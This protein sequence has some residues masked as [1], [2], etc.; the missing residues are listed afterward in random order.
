[1]VYTKQGGQEEAETICLENHADRIVFELLNKYKNRKGL[2]IGCGKG[3]WLKVFN[4]LDGFDISKRYIKN[5]KLYYIS[6]GF[7]C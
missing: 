3:R 6:R 5:C 7:K 1:M 4:N 2:E